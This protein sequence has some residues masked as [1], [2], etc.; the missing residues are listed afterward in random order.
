MSE[1]LWQKYR[2]TFCTSEGV[3]ISLVVGQIE[4][5]YFCCVIVI[6]IHRELLK[7][8]LTF[9]RSDSAV[10]HFMEQLIE[11]LISGM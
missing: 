9:S 6:I 5:N 4:L 2:S 7:F 8:V 1:E 10:V 3:F 11:Q